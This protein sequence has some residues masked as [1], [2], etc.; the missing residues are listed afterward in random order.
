MTISTHA[1]LASVEGTWDAGFE[2]VVQ[3]F[4]A[5]FIEEEDVGAALCVMKNGRAVVDVWA[6]WADHARTRRWERETPVLVFS[7]TKAVTATLIHLLVERGTVDIEAPVADYWP[8]FAAAGKDRITIRHVLTHQ[9]G[10]PLVERSLT[11]EE[12]F[13]WGPVVAAIERQAPLW[14]PGTAHGYHA[15]TFGWILGE[16]IRRV[17][18]KRVGEVIQDEFGSALLSEFHVGLPADA[19]EKVAE[20]MAPRP[21]E[22]PS[23][24][25]LLDAFMGPDTLTGKVL[26][27][28]GDLAYG[29]VWNSEALRAAELPSSNGIGTARSLAHFY[30]ALIGAGKTAP[31]VS[32]TTLRGALEPRSVG[33]DK[34]LLVESSF[35]SGYMLPPMLGAVCP[36][37]AFGHIGAGGSL[38]LADTASEIAFAYV[39]NTHEAWP[40]RRH[41][42]RP[43]VIVR[44]RRLTWRLLI[45][46]T[47][48]WKGKRSSSTAAPTHER[49]LLRREQSF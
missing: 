39:T 49:R 30:S 32:K 41:A 36:S 5:N 1:G 15:R 25:E 38:A 9:A 23:V 8:E 4:L 11:N 28:P 20:V 10:V 31:L 16:I 26:T 40:H 48:A 34:V 14:D 29:E 37:T 21:P 43:A 46:E 19:Q 47:D 3:G 7:A 22:D 27:G 2:A 6:G 33:P 13:A 42:S 45:A 18:G 44:I 24:A 35:G 17:T 12:V